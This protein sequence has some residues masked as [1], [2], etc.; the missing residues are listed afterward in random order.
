[1][2]TIRLNDSTGPFELDTELRESGVKIP[3]VFHRIPEQM[4]PWRLECLDQSGR[5]ILRSITTIL[6]R[7]V[8][9]A[10]KT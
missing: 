5:N 2:I 1:M 9:L 6:Q 8:G 3:E 4:E 10:T 7:K